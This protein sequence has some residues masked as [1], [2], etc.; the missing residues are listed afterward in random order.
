MLYYMVGSRGNR[1][2]VGGGGGADPP[3][4]SHKYKVSKQFLSRIPEKSQSNQASIQ[5]WAII[6]HLNGVS[7]AGR[8]LPFVLLVER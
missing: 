1:D 6:G 7:L 4:K 3:E 5:C 8:R 2:R